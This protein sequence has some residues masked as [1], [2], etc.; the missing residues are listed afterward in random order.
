MALWRFV[1]AICVTLAGSVALVAGIA[2]PAS[3]QQWTEVREGNFRL[4][5]P[6]RPDKSVQEVTVNGSGEVVDQIERTVTLGATEYFFS[7]TPYRRMPADLTPEQMLLNS[8]DGRPGHLLADRPLTV[9]GAPAREYVHEEDGWVLA[10][11]AIYAGDTLYQLIVV[12][13]A[14]AQTAPATRRFFESFSL[15]A[16]QA[17]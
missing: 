4:E 1:Y 5:M 7:H 15:A 9:S 11:R 8:R 3:A 12:G 17:P 13:R 6:G 10:T 14:G 16:R 2:S